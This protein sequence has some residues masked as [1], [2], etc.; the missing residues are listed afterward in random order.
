MK[1]KK[2]KQSRSTA[3]GGTPPAQHNLAR[4]WD[5]VGEQMFVPAHYEFS[6][7]DALAAYIAANP[8]GQL[9]SGH[10]GALFSTFVPFYAAPKKKHEK[11]RL[12]GH[13]AARNAQVVAIQEN[14]SAMAVFSSPGAYISPRWFCQNV[15]APTFSYVSVQA[16]GRLVPVDDPAEKLNILRLTVDHMESLASAGDDDEPWSMDML[17]QAQV[18]RYG[19]M[20]A[21]FYLEVDAIEG[22]ARLNQEKEEKDMRSIVEGL[23]AQ[24]NPGAQHIAALMRQNLRLVGR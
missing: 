21:A 3:P 7:P 18:D 14:A 22:V 8:V 5:N 10:K 24:E 11:L 12:A 6:N 4:T 20:V 9:V 15:T 13:M 2:E 16:R 1:E 23:S 19:P 17:T